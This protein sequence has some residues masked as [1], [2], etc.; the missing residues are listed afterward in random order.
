[1]AKAKAEPLERRIAFK[2]PVT[3]KMWR[4][5]VAQDINLLREAIREGANVNQQ[6]PDPQYASLTSSYLEGRTRFER[7]ESCHPIGY[8]LRVPALH[9]EENRLAMLSLL[10]DHADIST[11]TDGANALSRSRSHMFSD[12]SDCKITLDPLVAKS[13]QS[14]ISIH[15]YCPQTAEKLVEHLACIE[16]AA[17]LRGDSTLLDTCRRAAPLILAA[18]RRLGER[19]FRD[20]A[21]IF[22]QYD[23][24][25]CMRALLA[26]N[27]RWRND[28]NMTRDRAGGYALLMSA[29]GQGKPNVVHFLLSAESG[30]RI[31]QAGLVALSASAPDQNMRAILANAITSLRLAETAAPVESAPPPAAGTPTETVTFTHHRTIPPITGAT[32]QAPGTPRPQV[33]LGRLMEE[34]MGQ[35]G[36]PPD[37]LPQERNALFNALRNGRVSA[38]DANHIPKDFSAQDWAAVGHAFAVVA[39]RH[40][41]HPELRLSV[42]EGHEAAS[43]AGRG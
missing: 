42:R 15:N 31:D 34:F 3:D 41:N 43:A 24:V 26:R 10:A 18:D 21:Q 38:E 13:Q 12:E 30:I 5:L 17:Q 11:P 2:N 8:M 29:V 37:L 9:G 22:T 28:G 6:V 33:S 19:D 32:P 25:E 36:F 14:S 39:A 23:A 7:W 35:P 4:A 40:P 16:K 20:Y 27:D 1:M